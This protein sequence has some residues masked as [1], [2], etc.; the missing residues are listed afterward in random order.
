MMLKMESC[1]RIRSGTSSI[2][3][4]LRSTRRS[5]ESPLSDFDVSNIRET[6]SACILDRIWTL[7]RFS[8][9]RRDP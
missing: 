5:M 3:G 2:E 8:S 7:T 4:P 9:T 1:R 6:S